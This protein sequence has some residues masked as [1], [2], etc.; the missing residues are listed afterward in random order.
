MKSIYTVMWVE[1]EGL[2]FPNVYHQV[3]VYA[4]DHK[5]ALRRFNKNL[6]DGN[7]QCLTV[8]SKPLPE[9]FSDLP[10]GIAVTKIEVLDYPGV[11]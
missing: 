6:R 8:S 9:K 5:D 1:N 2:R 4:D 7:K 10:L 3:Y 11:E